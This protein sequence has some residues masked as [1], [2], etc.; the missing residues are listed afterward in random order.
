MNT[1]YTI[2][3]NALASIVEATN[4]L[5]RAERQLSEVRDYNKGDHHYHV[6]RLLGGC[7]NAEH[8]LRN[9]L[10]EDGCEDK[11]LPSRPAVR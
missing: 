10:L 2:L 3:S 11:E 1:Q 4:A 9:R 5:K 8:Y 6:F 7:Q